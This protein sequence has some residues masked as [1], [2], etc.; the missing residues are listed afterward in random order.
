MQFAEAGHDLSPSTGCRWRSWSGHRD[1]LS[2]PDALNQSVA[3]AWAS[4]EFFAVRKSGQPGLRNEYRDDLRPEPVR[5][6]S[7]RCRRRCCRSLVRPGGEVC[8]YALDTSFDLT[9]VPAEF[10]TQSHGHGIHEVRASALDHGP[11]LFGLGGQRC[12]QF[13]EGWDQ[14][15]HSRFRGG[16]MGGRRKVSL[17]DWDMFTSS[18]GGR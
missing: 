10:L 4:K 7:G 18:L 11:P 1:C 2:S 14:L 8:A 17:E 16:D 13:L 5:R 12:V 3:A 15:A 9:G 6:I